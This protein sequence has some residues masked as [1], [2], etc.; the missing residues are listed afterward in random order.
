MM[1]KRMIVSILRDL[2]ALPARARAEKFPAKMTIC[3][4]GN[5]EESVGNGAADAIR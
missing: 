4:V 2:P 3:D 5:R 1:N